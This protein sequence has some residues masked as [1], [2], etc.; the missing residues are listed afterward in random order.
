MIP[1]ILIR[2]PALAFPSFLRVQL[3]ERMLDI[4]DEAFDFW[5]HLQYS[6][7]IFEYFADRHRRD[8]HVSPAPVVVD[9]EDVVHNT[10]RLTAKLC[11]LYD[12]PAHGV[13]R[14]WSVAGDEEPLPEGIAP[15]F[16]ERLRQ[17]VG[18]ERGPAEVRIRTAG[19]CADIKSV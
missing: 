2:H 14:T 15:M 10:D 19:L 5:I 16:H 12:I 7:Y 18:I 1:I 17:S 4:E 8:P 9:A 6:K 13:R 3:T 11:Q